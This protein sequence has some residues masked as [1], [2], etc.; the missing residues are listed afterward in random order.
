VIVV[1]RGNDTPVFDQ[2][3]HVS[4]SLLRFDKLGT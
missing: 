1:H 2:Y 3:A 4:R